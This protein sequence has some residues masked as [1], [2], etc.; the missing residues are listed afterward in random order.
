MKWPKLQCLRSLQ[1]QSYLENIKQYCATN[2]FESGTETATCGIPQVSKAD[3]Y[4]DDN[5]ITVMSTNVDDLIQSAQ[6][7]LSNISTWMRVNKLSANPKKKQ[8]T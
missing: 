6:M 8:N 1:F 5:H 4:A 3:L 2:G 7:E